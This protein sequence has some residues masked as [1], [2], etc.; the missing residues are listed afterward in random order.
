M[1]LSGLGYD[2][3]PQ[4]PLSDSPAVL[5]I[6]DFQ[7]RYGLSVNG[8]ADQPTQEKGA[9]IVRNMRFSLA[10][11]LKNNLPID[12]YYDT[13]TRNAVRDFQSRIGLSVNGIATITVRKRL[14]EEARRR[15]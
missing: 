5:A 4:K 2:I 12:R 3:D 14:D 13:P 11:V 1:L 15:R 7:Q 6:R 8:R 10:K 9:A